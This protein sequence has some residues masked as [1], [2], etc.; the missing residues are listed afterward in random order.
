[1][2]GD[3]WTLGMLAQSGNTPGG[4]QGYIQQPAIATTHNCHPSP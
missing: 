3:G 2:C 1:L 4:V